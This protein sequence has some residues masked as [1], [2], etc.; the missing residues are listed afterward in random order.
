MRKLLVASLMAAG[1]T[2]TAK[3]VYPDLHRYLEM[4]RM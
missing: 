2:V 1:A 3:S 4:R